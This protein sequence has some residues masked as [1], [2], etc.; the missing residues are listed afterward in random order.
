MK[1]LKEAAG[2]YAKKMQEELKKM[3]KGEFKTPMQLSKEEKSKFFKHM[4]TVW[5][6]KKES[7]KEDK[8]EDAKSKIDAILLGSEHLGKKVKDY[9]MFVQD[10][11]KQNYPKDNYKS[12]MQIKDKAEQKN[13]FS[14][15]KKLWKKKKGEAKEASTVQ[16]EFFKRFNAEQMTELASALEIAK[17][18]GQIKDKVVHSQLLKALNKALDSGAAE[19]TEEEK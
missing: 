9:F 11:L 10:Q 16:E 12:P 15:V 3:Y 6:S 5:K 4:D 1:N 14:Q 18:H 19:V 7:K 2:S 8:K 17:G 13:F